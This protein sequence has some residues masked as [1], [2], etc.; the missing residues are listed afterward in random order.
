[1]SIF[2]QLL[3]LQSLLTIAACIFAVFVLFKWF[4]IQPLSTKKT[5]KEVDDF[6]E[7]KFTLMIICNKMSVFQQLLNLQSLITIA[8]CIFAVFVLFKWFLI[9]PISTK[10][11]PPSPPKLPIIGNLHQLGLFPH[12]SLGA[13]A[14]CYGPLML[15]HL[16]KVPVLVVS[17]ADAACEIVRNVIF[18]NQPKL[19]PFVKLLNGFIDIFMAPYGEYLRKVKSLFVVQ[20]LSNKR[21]HYSFRDVRVEKY[22]DQGEVGSKFRKQFKDFIELMATFHV[23]DYIPWQ[24]WLCYFN[25]LNA[26]LKKTSKEVDDFLEV[27]IQE[28]ENRMSNNSQVEDHKDFID[29]LLCL[30]KENILDFPIDKA[31]F[32]AIFRFNFQLF[33]GK[34]LVNLKMAENVDEGNENDFKENDNVSQEN[35]ILRRNRPFIEYV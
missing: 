11:S 34:V 17:S 22:S 30:Q 7:Y 5:L 8:A 19:T 21:I 25:S 13:L 31:S 26:K 12:C 32:A 33:L 3:N 35:E 28:H 9:Q 23:G 14:Q 16:G 1:M 27:V 6:L 15:L 2:Q 29:V 18:A 10:K 24:G 4:L 20:L